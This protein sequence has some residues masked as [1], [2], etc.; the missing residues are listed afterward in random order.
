MYRDSVPLHHARRVDQQTA[1]SLLRSPAIAM[2]VGG[3]TESSAFAQNSRLDVPRVEETLDS[4]ANRTILALVLALLRRTRALGE[5]L[6][7]LV[8]RERPS[9][10]RTALA[11]RWPRRKQFLDSLS[12]KLKVLLHLSPFA[13]VQRAE[14]TAA[15]LTAIASDPIY[16]RAWSRGWRR[17]P[18][19]RRVRQE[20][21]AAMG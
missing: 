21:G 20:P 13:E 10:T 5:R 19:R 1:A 6:Q 2:F 17:P 8:D 12:A 16:S 11:A 15:G 9:E 3:A 4:A 14:I 7:D 18:P